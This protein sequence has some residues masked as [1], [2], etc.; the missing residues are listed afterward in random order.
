MLHPIP[1]CVISPDILQLSM[2][3]A[4][5]VFSVITCMACGNTHYCNYQCNVQTVQYVHAVMCYMVM[6]V[7]VACTYICM[8]AQ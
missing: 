8:Q 3:A 2:P 4:V 5:M 1:T 6:I 7:L